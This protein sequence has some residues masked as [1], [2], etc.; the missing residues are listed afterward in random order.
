MWNIKQL[1]GKAMK[2]SILALTLVNL[3]VASVFGRDYRSL[4]DSLLDYAAGLDARI[5]ICF[6]DGKDTVAVNADEAFPM[7]SVVKFPLALA[8]AR[9]TGERRGSFMDEV[10]VKAS[11]LHIDTYSPMLNKY[12]AGKDCKVAIS[13]LLEYSLKY[14]DNNACDILIDYVGGMDSLAYFI[15]GFVPEGIIVK[16]TEDDMHKDLMASYDNTATP[17]AMAG[18]IRDFDLNGADK[19]DLEIKKIMESCETGTDRLA[20]PFG[21]TGVVIGHKTGTGPVNPETRRIIAVN[22]CGYVHLRD[23][24]RYAIAVF[25]ADSGY[26]LDDTSAI[27][28]HISEMVKET[29]ESGE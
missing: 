9:K 3:C 24:K 22:D 23:G 17:R 7:L 21:G 8:V 16:R 15:K 10:Y 26:T 2:V 14:S 13:E 11:Q 6:T 27:I 12:P 25:V 1:C 20:K 18:L 29:I 5:G 28:A 19:Y 4:E